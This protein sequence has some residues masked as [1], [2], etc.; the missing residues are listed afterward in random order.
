[1]F[2]CFLR[3]N[4]LFVSFLQKKK[5]G[6]KDKQIPHII[7]EKSSPFMS[8]ILKKS[9]ILTFCK[10]NIR[11]ASNSFIENTYFCATFLSVCCTNVRRIK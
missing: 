11:F 5:L 2:Y 8:I 1:M 9:Q 7:A 6:R 4:K 3:C 10:Y